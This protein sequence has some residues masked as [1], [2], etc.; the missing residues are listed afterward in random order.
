MFCSVSTL[1]ASDFHFLFKI[2][3]HRWDGVVSYL[4]SI[5]LIVFLRLN[6]PAYLC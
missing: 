1:L 4:A 2:V 3:R 6:W 5:S